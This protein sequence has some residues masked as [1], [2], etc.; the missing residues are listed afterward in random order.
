MART[1]TTTAAKTATTRASASR[2][3]DSEKTMGG[4]VDAPSVPDAN[5]QPEGIPA[6]S[7][8]AEATDTTTDVAAGVSRPACRHTVTRARHVGR[9]IARICDDCGE[10]V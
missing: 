1:R 4:T 6:T 5:P 10:R 8:S 9:G 7:A 3:P 2:R